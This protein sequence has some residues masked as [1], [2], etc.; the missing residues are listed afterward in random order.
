MWDQ[1]LQEPQALFVRRADVQPSAYDTCIYD[2]TCIC[3][4]IY[5]WDAVQSL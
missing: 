3:D 2:A 1:F 4:A 5:F